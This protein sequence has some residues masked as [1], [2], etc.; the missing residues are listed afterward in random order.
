MINSYG[1]STFQSHITTLGNETSDGHNLKVKGLWL[2]A[3]NYR[4]TILKPMEL[5]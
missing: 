5:S 4:K 1:K 3:N 2:E